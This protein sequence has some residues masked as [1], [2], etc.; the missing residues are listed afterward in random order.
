[1]NDCIFCKIVKGEIPCYKIYEDADFLAFLDISPFNSGHTL[2][3]PKKHYR[4]V[5]EVESGGEYFLIAQK[6][7]KALQ[8]AFNTDWVVSVVI[9]EAVPHAHLQL[10]PRTENDG[11]GEALN[12]NNRK[13]LSTDQFNEVVKKVTQ[14]L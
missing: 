9:G 7:A 10:I 6:I 1:M 2:L 14:N 5:W 3:I 13:K 4:W 8:K 11:H 12:F